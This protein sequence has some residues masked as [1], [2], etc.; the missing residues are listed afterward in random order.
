MTRTLRIV[1]FTDGGGRAVYDVNVPEGETRV[2]TYNLICNNQEGGRL[3]VAVNLAD[4]LA[5]EDQMYQRRRP[6]LS[7]VA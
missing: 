3:P 4:D 1:A 6:N 2:S 5:D 7:V